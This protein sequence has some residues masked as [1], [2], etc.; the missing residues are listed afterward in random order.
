M[1]EYDKKYTL[2]ERQEWAWNKFWQLSE[3]KGL[4]INKT[5]ELIGCVTA[6][7]ISGIRNGT[8]KANP[9]E[10]LNKLAAYFEIKE[11]AAEQAKYDSY[12]PTSISSQVYEIINNCHL[13]GGLAVACGDA[14]I[15]K[16]QAALKYERD[17]T[18]NCIYIYVPPCM[19]SSNSIIKAI[20]KKL[21]VR[22]RAIDDLW[23]AISERLTDGM[24]I[25]L[26][27]AQH[28]SYEAIE[29]L[30][31]FSDVFNNS[32][33]TLGICLIGN[34]VTVESTT[35]KSGHEIE[36]GQIV[37]RRKSLEVFKTSQ[38][39]RHDIE[40][41]FPELEGNKPEIDFLHNV[42]I[43]VQ[44]IRGIVDIMIKAKANDNITYAGLVAA[45]KS[46]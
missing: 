19:K 1:V 32:G 34:E 39:M 45:A 30:R 31:S 26:D 22:K 8:Y 37:S 20:G 23:T 43:G 27:E 41:L 13:L 44:G 17:H 11:A 21:G 5:A 42:A 35:G 10:Q 4:S 24:I 15:G 28:L 2:S 33:K 18:S 6:S 29:T 14:G 25:I 40:L 3:E 16:T 38:I 46:K 9:S 7:T 12:V 36:F